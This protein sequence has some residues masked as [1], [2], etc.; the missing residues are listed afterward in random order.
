[1]STKTTSKMKP[2]IIIVI[3]LILAIAAFFITRSIINVRNMKAALDFGTSETDIPEDTTTLDDI[4]GGSLTNDN[5]TFSAL[6]NQNNVA[7]NDNIESNSMEFEDN[8]ISPTNN[9]EL[10]NGN[11]QF[12]APVDVT[13]NVVVAPKKAIVNTFPYKD[14]P[15]VYVKK[16]GKVRI[17]SFILDYNKTRVATRNNP[18]LITLIM[19]APKEARFARVRVYARRLSSNNTILTRELVFSLPKIYV[20]NGQSQTQFYFAGRT[21]RGYYLPKGRYLLYAEA[22]ITDS[23]GNSVGKT[24]RY[25]LPKWNYIITLK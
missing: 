22:E 11:G 20:I 24:G 23:D 3:I 4:F 8:T 2:I 6:S 16:E 19:N 1:M 18:L 5:M 13:T 14:T 10:A 25:P 17:S 21:T 7:T 9:I 15:Y 12:E